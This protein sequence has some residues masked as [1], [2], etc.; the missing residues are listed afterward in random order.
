MDPTL[1]AS[2]PLFSGISRRRHSEVA[3]L[4]DEVTLP[5][6]SLL[7]REGAWA[8]EFFVLVEG[9]AEVS[10]GSSTVAALGPGDFLGEVGLL[11]GPKRS[12]TVVATSPVRLL[13]SSPRDL[14]SLMYRF[15]QV[16]DRVR[17]AFAARTQ[18]SA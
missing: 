2:I 18:G 4:A 11:A 14:S 1:V 13:V 12:A 3:A 10:V 7:T 6:G 17:A 8:E 9:T 5:A 15:P 16:A